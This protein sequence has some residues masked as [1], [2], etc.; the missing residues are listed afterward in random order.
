MAEIL[1]RLAA[2]P[3]PEAL[4]DALV[5]MRRDETAAL[6]TAMRACQRS[7]RVTD[8]MVEAMS[9]HIY[10]YALTN[11]ADIRAGLEAALTAAL[12][13]DAATPPN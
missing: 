1:A 3:T 12:E 5:A 10:Q 6:L 8:A 4:A 13:D 2:S 11:R 9:E 7:P